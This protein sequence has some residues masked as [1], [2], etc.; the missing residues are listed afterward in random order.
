MAVGEWLAAILSHS[1][2]R[3]GIT[4]V[5]VCQLLMCFCRCVSKKIYIYICDSAGQ[6]NGFVI[7]L[8]SKNHYRNCGGFGSFYI[9]QLKVE[10]SVKGGVIEH[11]HT[12]CDWLITPIY[13]PFSSRLIGIA[14]L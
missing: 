6:R 1:R 5:S 7:L 9:R 14:Y 12:R 11:L 8:N 13:M 2:V 10:R 4:S 3:A